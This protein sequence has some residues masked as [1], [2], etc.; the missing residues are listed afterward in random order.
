MRLSFEPATIDDAA[1]LA[2][3]HTATA[4]ALT[5]RH[6]HGPW[7]MKTSAQGMIN[8]M[9]ISQVFVAR[10]NGGILGTLRLTAKKPW[11]I[12]TSFFSVSR[13]PVYL[14]AMAVAPEW[15]RQGIG[16]RCL[17]EAARVAR[18]WP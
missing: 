12:D 16:R 5:A 17:E 4:D 8:A 3:L 6:G 13:S 10:E 2:A 14:L 7:S 18:A 1:A 11:A 15:Q 9:R